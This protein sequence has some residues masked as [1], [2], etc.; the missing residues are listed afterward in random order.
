MDR[1]QFFA[2]LLGTFGLI[3]PPKKHAV[4]VMQERPHLT[5]QEYDKLYSYILLLSKKM[6]TLPPINLKD[7]NA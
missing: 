6:Q 3:V 7:N 4:L 2:S 5:I 1:R